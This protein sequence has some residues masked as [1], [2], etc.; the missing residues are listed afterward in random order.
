MRVLL[1]E[2]LPVDLS[3]ELRDHVVDTV[4]GRGWAGINNGELLRRMRGQYD[5][6]AARISVGRVH[7]LARAS[8]LRHSGPAKTGE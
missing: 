5:V 8:L 6:L 1:D 2:Q 7:P 4:V 3:A